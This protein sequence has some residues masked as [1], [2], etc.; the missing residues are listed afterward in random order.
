MA[1]Y[2][3]VFVFLAFLAME[4]EFKTI[5]RQNFVIAIIGIF[6]ILFTGFRAVSVSRDYSSYLDTFNY[7]MHSD[8]GGQATILPLF[9]PGFVFIV[10]MCYHIFHNNGALAIML[11]FAALSISIKFFVF[12]KIAF[13][14]FIVLLLY[15]SHYFF[16]EEMTQIRNG[17]AC[18]FFFLAIYYHLRNE[19]AK[20]LGCIFVAALFHNSAIFYLLLFLIKKDRFNAW[21]YAG[22]FI[23]AII[24]GLVRVQFLPYIL[25]N[26]NLAM[27][28]TKLTSYAE[29]ADSSVYEQIRF[30]NVLNT[31]NVFLTAYIFFYCVKNKIQDPRLFLF[32]K[33]NIISLFVYGLF[34][35]VPSMATRITELFGVVF[36]LLF[37][38]TL[39]ISPL[40]KWNILLLIGVSLVY[41]YINIFYG[42]LINPYEI[43]RINGI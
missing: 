42:K 30:F 10:K 15:Y 6:F 29:A 13:N 27:I 43:V 41:F 5:E 36:P 16:I 23:S 32:L 25:P 3:F 17:L 39:R 22:I 8:G 11:V 21:L 34:I 26:A 24:L 40:K 1:I 7:I 9:E 35:D 4:Y 14:P 19:K 37:A 28:S 18:S 33:C 2:C 31:I 38:Y 12:R 20:V